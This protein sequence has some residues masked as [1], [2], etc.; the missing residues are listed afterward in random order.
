MIPP[1]LAG[2][3]HVRARAT[4]MFARTAN[5]GSPGRSPMVLTGVRGVGKTVTLL[6]V[7]GEASNNGYVVARLMVDR[8]GS[9]TTR[10]AASIA[11]A[12]L[13]LGT[14]KGSR[15]NKWKSRMSRLSV[16]VSVAGVVKVGTP[17]AISPAAGSAADRDSLLALVDESAHLARA[18]GRPGLCMALD[19]IQEGSPEGLGAVTAIAQSLIGSPLVI[20]A[21]GLPNT[22]DRLMAAGSYAERFQ[23]LTLGPLNSPDAAAALLV[24]ATERQVRWNQDA[25][26]LILGRA[27]GAP[28]L[29]QLFGDAAWRAASPLLG[30]HI[31]LRHAQVGA[32]AATQELYSG[33]FRGRWNKASEL[34]QQYLV[35]MAR[36]LDPAGTA[37]GRDVATSMGRTT[38]G[39]NYIRTRLL[40][41]GL[42]QPAERGRIA[43]SLPGFEHFAIQAMDGRQR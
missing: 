32:D 2:R 27:A 38:T 5:F 41:K 24:P 18:H 33:L 1:L 23:Y 36:L 19:E 21:A 35:A 13:T 37:A 39:V 42:I 30:G 43:F 15:W 14:L 31:A 10:I 22:R 29:L 7:A 25:A 17:G 8:H 4:E 11:E 26:E 20:L 28:Y 34:E 6:A 40:D 12:M 3:E 16:E 9:L